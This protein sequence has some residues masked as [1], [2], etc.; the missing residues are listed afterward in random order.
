M[1]KVKSARDG[2][3]DLGLSQ[4]VVKPEHWAVC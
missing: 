4:G 2:G 1:L 3:A